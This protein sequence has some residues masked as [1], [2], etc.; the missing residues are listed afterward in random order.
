M[1]VSWELWDTGSIPGLAR[2]LKDLALPQL[3]LKSQPRLGPDPRLGTPG[4]GVGAKK[5]KTNKTQLTLFLRVLS[6][7][8]LT[9]GIWKFPD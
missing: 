9:R 8:G 3:W 7:K 6:F 5:K 2:W 4:H 1:A